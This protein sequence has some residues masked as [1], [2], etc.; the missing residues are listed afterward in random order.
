MPIDSTAK[1]MKVPSFGD[2]EG[3]DCALCGAQ[4]GEVVIEHH[5]FGED[6]RV[7]RCSSCGLIR[8]NPRPTPTWKMHF[9]D[10]DFN[11]YAESQGR[12]FIYAPDLRRLL[13]YAQLL[14]LIGSYC[15]CPSTL[16]DVGCAA[17]LFVHEAKAFGYEAVGCDYS[18]KAIAWGRREFGVEIICSPAEA[19][20]APDCEYDV[21]TLLHVFEHLPDPIG[22]L[23]E[24]RRI[25][26]PGG[27]LFLETVNYSA[28]YQIEKRL[29]FFI[30]FYNFVT[31]RQGLPWVPFDHLYHWTPKTLRRAMKDAG[32]EEFQTHHLSGYRSEGKPNSFFKLIYAGAE[33]LTSAINKFSGGRNDFWPVLLATGRK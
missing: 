25:L 7:V 12:D 11:G 8:T 15:P 26:K 2:L 1:F 3:C 33:L 24:M 28:H 9:Y 27:M 5:M 6:F 17:G 31:R 19:V 30:P 22:V 21:V 13:G 14:K 4:D 32:F 20:A 16:I 29:R 23:R 18:V 10:P